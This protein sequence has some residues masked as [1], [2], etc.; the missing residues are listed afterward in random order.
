M[1]F[2]FEL[3]DRLTKEQR[4]KNMQAVKATGSKIESSLAKELWALGYR[5]RKNDRTVYGK[6]DL[7]IKRYKLAI[8]VDSEFWHGKDW[9][10]RKHDLKSNQDFWYKKIEGNI[11]RDNQ[12]NDFLLKSGWTVL[13]FWGTD[14]TKNLRTCTDKIIEIIN[15]IKRENKH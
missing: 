2:F 12:V 6:P 13:R 8:F 15:E 11:K 10:E 1:H 14:I 7:T 5:Y 4:R 9:D 3:K